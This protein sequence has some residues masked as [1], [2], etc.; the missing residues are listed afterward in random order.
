MNPGKKAAKAEI[1]LVT[2]ASAG[3]GELFARRFAAGRRHVALVA[4]R[5]ER[6]DALAAELA[7][8]H[9]IDAV[10]LEYD[11]QRPDAPGELVADLERRGY[12]VDTLVNNAGFGARGEF[13]ELGRER[14]VGMVDLNV[15]SLVDLTH[16]VLPGMI[17]R[18]RGGI[19][20]VASTAA[21]Q[22]GPYMAVY[23][24]TKA[25]VLSWS[26]ALHEELKPHGIH[27]SA[28]CPGPT[29]TEFGDV[30]GMKDTALFKLFGSGA[31]AVVRDGIAGLERNVAVNVS[32]VMNGVMAQSAR[33][34]PRFLMRRIAGQLQRGR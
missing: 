17:A 20:N 6:L 12:T 4:R 18:K 15:R 7:K 10:P 24:A 30:A 23:Y 28:L 13:A 34:T 22:P 8:A 29:S 3:L 31:D 26:E 2:G 14:Q 21:F 1:V 5:R 9:G 11:L 25:F 33:V 27:V 16:R 19:L 32:G